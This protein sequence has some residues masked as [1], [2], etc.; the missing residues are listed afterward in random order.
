MSDSNKGQLAIDIR[1]YFAVSAVPVGIF[2]NAVSLSVFITKRLNNKNIFG[3]MYAWLCGLNFVCLT[4]EMIFALY[5]HF[6]INAFSVSDSTCK[7][8]YGWV[9]FVTHV[10]SFQMILIAFYLYVS[11]FCKSIINCFS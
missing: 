4:N 8:V 11:M 2:L 7:T 5:G 9:K 6:N 1:F 10:P 3:I